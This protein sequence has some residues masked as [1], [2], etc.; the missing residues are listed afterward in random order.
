MGLRAERGAASINPL[1]VWKE[2]HGVATDVSPTTSGSRENA[3]LSSHRA[4][5]AHFLA[6][7]A[8]RSKATNLAEHVTLHRVMD[9]VYKSAEDGRDVAL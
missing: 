5:W 7:V 1:T 4:E 6:V 8:G 3:W 2:L 9:A